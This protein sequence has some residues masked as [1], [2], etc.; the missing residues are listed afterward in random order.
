[1]IKQTLAVWQG[2]IRGDVFTLYDHR[3][4]DLEQQ[5]A[6]QKTKKEYNM[7]TI[8]T[9]KDEERS[10]ELG[11]DIWCLTGAN[12]T[13]FQVNFLHMSVTTLGDKTNV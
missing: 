6:I 11:M 4:S 1:M 8:E 7:L 5:E 13:S 9:T 3:L 12:S 2:I 10:K